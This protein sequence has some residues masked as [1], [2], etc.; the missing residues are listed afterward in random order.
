MA[1][2]KKYISV[3]NDGTNDLYIKDAEAQ[4]AISELQKSVTGAMHFLGLST[5]AI[6]DEAS[7]GPWVIESKTYIA[8]GTPEE[9]QILLKAGDAAL[10]GKKEFVW[11]GSMWREYGDMSSLKSL[12]YKDASDIETAGSTSSKMVTASV[13]GVSGSTFV[14]GVDG[15]T[16]VYG[17]GDKATVH[18]TPTLNTTDIYG[19]GDNATVH[20]TPTL[21]TSDIYGCGTDATV[22]SAS[23]WNDGTLASM[24]YDESNEKLTFVAGTKPS[25]TITSTTVATKAASAT[26]VGTS[27]SE[28]SAIT[29]ATKAAS[30][31]SVG[32]GIVD[33]TAVTVATKAAS[34]TT[35]PVAA[36]AATTV[37]VAAGS[38]TTVA[39]G[40]LANDGAGASV[41]T[42]V[43]TTI[44]NKPSV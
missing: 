24:T 39:T 44:Q 10:Y 15:S 42:A 5:T 35:V 40:A 18:D 8:S 26:A 28:G 34:A 43:S 30:A 27:L 11:N 14:T 29:V 16:T 12:A 36:S 17:C 2:P 4:Q 31:T 38:A 33:G 20:D 41:V 37:P 32:T 19:C 23:A 22:G 1:G 9:G 3:F 7:T 13:T 6:T 25:L 21:N